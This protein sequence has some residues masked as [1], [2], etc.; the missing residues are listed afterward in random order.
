MKS[1]L[2][3]PKLILSLLTGLCVSL[4]VSAQQSFSDNFVEYMAG[5]E[6]YVQNELYG[7]VSEF[8]YDVEET[9]NGEYF[10]SF[11]LNIKQGLDQYHQDR[12]GSLEEDER[13][14]AKAYTQTMLVQLAELYLDR[15]Q[16][17]EVKEKQIFL[18]QYLANTG[19][20]KEIEQLSDD[21]A[22]SL[23]M[24]LHSAMKIPFGMPN[25]DVPNYVRTI[26][27][28]DRELF[29]ASLI[30]NDMLMLT[31]T[32]EESEEAILAFKS[33]FAS[34]KFTPAL[35]ESLV[36]LEKLKTGA[37]VENF[38][39]VNLNG[40]QVSLSDF[41][42]KIIYLDLW[43]SWCGPCIQTFRT[44]TPDFEMQL[45]D[46]EDIVLMYVSIDETEEPWKKYLDKNPM[47]GIHVYAGQ[48]FDAEI[49]KY[50]KVWGIPRYLIIG[51]NNKLL[52]PNAPRPG[53][54]AISK[55]LELVGG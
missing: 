24:A 9:P 17:L 54:E 1:I 41:K 10:I 14:L 11:V 4:S 43:A 47:R 28:E 8:L 40:D 15:A 16:E 49:M 29:L 7:Q 31:G 50:F 26:R 5:L 6:S 3:F 18:H 36:S 52:T 33:E 42:D 25:S 53:D 46:Q 35:N 55:L 38:S 44:K 20:N 51:K 27:G 34:S 12:V 48:G 22:R 2:N 37:P 30:I 45:R 23:M 32:Y 39:F 19:L 13:A 21:L